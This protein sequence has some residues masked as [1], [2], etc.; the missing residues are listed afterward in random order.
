MNT[1][2]IFIFSLPRAGSTLLQRILNQHNDIST[3]P[4]PWIALPLFYMLKTEGTKSIYGHKILANAVNGFIDSFPNKRDDYLTTAAEF[5]TKMYSLSSESNSIYF[6]DKTPR[7]HLIINELLDSFPDAKFIFLWR[8]PLAI[9]ASMINTWGKGSWN[10]YMFWIDLY[11][12]IDSMTSSFQNNKER[13]IAVKYEDLVT[14]PDEAILKIMS[15]LKLEYNENIVDTFKHAKKIDGARRGDPTGQHKYNK[16]SKGSLDNWK[17]TLANPFRK[18]WSKNYLNWVGSERLKIMGYD[19]NELKSEI[20]SQQLD[21]KHLASDIIRN[22]Y[23]KI[24]CKYSTDIIRKN[25]PWDKNI[26]FCKN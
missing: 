13:C 18:S 25:T 4:E 15:Y 16:V 5:L 24:Y 10:L 23:G 19:I 9:A 17:K 1:Q 2:P 26:Y 21:Y 12:G 8:N 20:N 11:R 6:L 14:S 22:T 3:A 7:Y